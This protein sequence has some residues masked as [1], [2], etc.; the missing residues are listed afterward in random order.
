[1]TGYG[2]TLEGPGPSLRVGTA[3][4]LSV[5]PQSAVV[6]IES[7]REAIYI[8]DFAAVHRITP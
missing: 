4:V 8:G 6:R 7:S 1:M 3:R 5:L 2:P